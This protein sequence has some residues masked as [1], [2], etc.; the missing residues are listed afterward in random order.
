MFGPGR[1]YF[2]P[3]GLACMLVE[4]RGGR[5]DLAEF[6][7]LNAA[8]CVPPRGQGGL[9]VTLAGDWVCRVSRCE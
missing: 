7:G 2:G 6:R 4:W 1:C 3:A 5:K 8:Y 9:R